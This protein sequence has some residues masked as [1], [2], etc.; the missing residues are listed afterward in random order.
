MRLDV[1]L[2]EKGYF[3]SRTKSKQAI[4]RGEVYLNG[5]Q[6]LKSSLSV[7]ENSFEI[8]IVRENDFVSLGGYKLHKALTDF[9]LDVKDLVVADVGASTGG[10]TDCLLKFGAKSVYSVDLNDGQLHDKLRKDKR[11]HPIIKNARELCRNDFANS[12][13]MI[14]ADLSFISATCVLDVFANLIDDGKKIILLIKPQFE[15]GEK[16]KRKNGIVKDVKIHNS[17]CRKI[18]EYAVSVS[19]TPLDFTVAPIR[20]GK[21]VEF[22][23][24]LEKNSE[25]PAMDVSKIKYSQIFE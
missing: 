20:E 17:V 1:F 25:K 8:K 3:D 6:A 16:K 22:L 23:M 10:F 2:V 15:T 11:V 18:F 13:D 21:N 14:V 24:L 4:E 7:D 5:K 19:L 9:N 12:L